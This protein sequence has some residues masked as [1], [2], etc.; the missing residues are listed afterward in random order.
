MVFRVIGGTPSASLA[1]VANRPASRLTPLSA[2]VILS[3][4]AQRCRATAMDAGPTQATA[5]SV[6]VCLAWRSVAGAGNEIGRDAPAR[7][8]ARYATPC[9]GMPCRAWAVPRDA[10]G[11]TRDI[12]RAATAHPRG[13]AMLG[14]PEPRGGIPRPHPLANDT[15]QHY[16]ASRL[17][18]P[19]PM[20]RRDWTPKTWPA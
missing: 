1:F 16:V 9:L 14:R 17:V 5:C 3:G 2:A 7:R 6:A 13:L 15:A 8:P 18:E 4:R 19:C 20:P 12:W 10:S 11:G